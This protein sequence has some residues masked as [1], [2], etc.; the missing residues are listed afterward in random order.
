MRRLICTGRVSIYRECCMNSKNRK[1]GTSSSQSVSKAPVIQVLCFA[2]RFPKRN[3][4]NI[5]KAVVQVL[6]RFWLL[7]ALSIISYSWT[8]KKE[9]LKL[10]F[11]NMLRVQVKF[12]Y[13]KSLKIYCNNS[14]KQIG[15]LQCDMQNQLQSTSRIHFFF[16]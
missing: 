6:V 8:Q 9:I 13:M 5:C 16:P 7:L 12:I 4:C 15:F 2:D 3:Y 10:L 11:C 1:N 14:N